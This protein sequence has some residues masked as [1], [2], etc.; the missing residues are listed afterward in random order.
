[1]SCINIFYSDST[2][3][4]TAIALLLLVHVRTENIPMWGFFQSFSVS[5][6]TLIV[7]LHP[8]NFG[9]MFLQL[10]MMISTYYRVRKETFL[11]SK[12]NLSILLPQRVYFLEKQNQKYFTNHKLYENRMWQVEGFTVPQVLAGDHEMGFSHTEYVVNGTSS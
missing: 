4:M 5:L 2:D 3:N 6:Q 10:R 11:L 7:P 9:R 12:V 8:L 1:M